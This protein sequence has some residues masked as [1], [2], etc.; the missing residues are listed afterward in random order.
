MTPRTDC[1]S[2]EPAGPGSITSGDNGE[3]SKVEEAGAEY[4]LAKMELAGRTLR[5]QT[6]EDDG[7]RYPMTL[8]GDGTADRGRAAG[9]EAVPA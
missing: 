2:A 8:A 7:D 4:K 3:L 5:F 1:P 9:G 6:N